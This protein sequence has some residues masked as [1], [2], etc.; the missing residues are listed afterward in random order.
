MYL[1]L[2]SVPV[3]WA[4]VCLP[5]LFSDHEEFAEPKL[6]IMTVDVI[7]MILSVFTILFALKTQLTDPGI[8][9]R[10]LKAAAQQA[11]GDNNRVEENSH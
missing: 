2:L 7:L 4:S 11:A 3:I 10:D 6:P 9:Y 8:I 5:F 1:I